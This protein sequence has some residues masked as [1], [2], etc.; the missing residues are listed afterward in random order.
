[1][2]SESKGAVFIFCQLN[3][4]VDDL[5]ESLL[6]FAASACSLLQDLACADDSN[7]DGTSMFSLSL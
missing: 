7:Y 3:H 1:M 6:W 4:D 5:L 2:L